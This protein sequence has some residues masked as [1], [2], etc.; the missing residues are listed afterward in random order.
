MGKQIEFALHESLARVLTKVAMLLPAVLA[1]VLAIVIAAIVG[2]ALAYVVR[3]FL[4]AVRFDERIHLGHG[5]GNLEWAAIHHPTLVLSRLVFWGCMV[6]GVVIGV[7]AFA[8]G[9][10][11]SEVMATFM[12]PY[13]AHTI[14]AA[15]LLVVGMLAARFLARSVLIGAVN[16]NLHYARLLSE[17]VK[18]LVIVLTVAMALDHLGIGSRIVALAFGI[19]FGG[20]VLTLS[21]S[22]GLSSRDIVIRTLEQDNARVSPTETSQSGITHF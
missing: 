5:A 21:L 13:V 19:L 16:M 8:S 11:N 17:G 7:A 4:T 1:L 3:R 2:L 15:I 14:G 6:V 22:I 10:S 18:W 20:I 9:Y 12:F